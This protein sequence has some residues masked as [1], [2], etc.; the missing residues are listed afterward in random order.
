MKKIACSRLKLIPTFNFSIPTLTI[1]GSAGAWGA[2]AARGAAARAGYPLHRIGTQ[3][4]PL[5]MQR[6][7]RRQRSWT[8]GSDP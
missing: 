5:T 1:G 2:D 7:G 4:S 6:C 3:V 8:S